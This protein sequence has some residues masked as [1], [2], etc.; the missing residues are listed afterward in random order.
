MKRG[1]FLTFLKPDHSLLATLVSHG[2]SK[3]ANMVPIFGERLLL[4]WVSSC[5]M[6]TYC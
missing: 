5:I 6:V 3:K 1:H 2:I 4:L